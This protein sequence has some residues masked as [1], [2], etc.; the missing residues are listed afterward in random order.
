MARDDSRGAE[1]FETEEIEL[2]GTRG[3]PPLEQHTPA[4]Q[5]GETPA[6]SPAPGHTHTHTHTHTQT[7]KNTHTSNTKTQTHTQLSCE[8]ISKALF[9]QI[10]YC[11]CVW[12]LNA[13][14]G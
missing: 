10:G 14:D 13:Q 8:N 4:G 11:V 12:M 2:L 5:Q 1:A 9:P 7:H 3:E 6:R